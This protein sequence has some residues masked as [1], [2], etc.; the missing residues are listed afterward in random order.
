MIYFFFILYE[1]EYENEFNDV[2]FNDLHTYI[3]SRIK[4]IVWILRIDVLTYILY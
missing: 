4:E 1:S 2:P 3:K